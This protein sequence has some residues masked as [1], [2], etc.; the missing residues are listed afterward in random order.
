MKTK[1]QKAKFRLLDDRNYFVRIDLESALRRG[2]LI[3][4]VFVAGASMPAAEQLPKSIQA[5]SYEMAL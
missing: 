3:I 4:P 1:G 2:P 5:F